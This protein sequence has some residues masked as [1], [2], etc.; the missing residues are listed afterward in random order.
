MAYILASHA[1]RF[2]DCNLV[3]PTTNTKP[4]GWDT[5]ASTN[6]KLGCW[7][8]E[9]EVERMCHEQ[10][11]GN[12][13]IS[14]KTGAIFDALFLHTTAFTNCKRQANAVHAMY[15]QV[16]AFHACKCHG[17]GMMTKTKPKKANIGKSG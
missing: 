11:D 10:S 6:I 14:Q 13:Q 15:M 12:A 7:I 1:D 2:D 3:K 8:R 4:S 9:R 17:S 16:P 5:N